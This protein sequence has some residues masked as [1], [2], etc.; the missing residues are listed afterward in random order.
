M[1]GFFWGMKKQLIAD[2]EIEIVEPGCSPGSGRYGL[3]IVTADDISEIMPYINAIAVNAWYDHEN[4]TLVLKEPGQAFAMR[5]HEVRIARLGEAASAGE[6][7]AA[8]VAKINA[9]WAEREKIVPRFETRDLPSVIDILKLLPRTNCRQCGYA[10]CLAFAAALRSLQAEVEVCAPLRVPGREAEHRKIS[11]L[12]DLRG[13]VLRQHLLAVAGLAPKT[14][15]NLF[16]SP[17]WQ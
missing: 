8:V 14:G 9:I 3:R 15:R 1:A 5:P 2:Y 16:D 7:S 13:R 6:V 11:E 4:N 17:G 10:T 12:C